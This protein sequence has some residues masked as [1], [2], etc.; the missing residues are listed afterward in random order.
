[1]PKTIGNMKLYSTLELSKTLDITPATLR[2]YIKEGRIRGQKFGTKWYVSEGSL[3]RFFE[4]LPDA[5]AQ[6]SQE[7]KGTSQ[8]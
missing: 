8:A 5:P 3:K 7:Q 6:P 1:M 4:G 2:A